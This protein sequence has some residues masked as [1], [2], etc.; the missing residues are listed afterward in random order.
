MDI[1]QKKIKVKMHRSLILGALVLPG[2]SV[3][4]HGEAGASVFKVHGFWGDLDGEG[5]GA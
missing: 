5:G 1:D 3:V 2:Q 4:G